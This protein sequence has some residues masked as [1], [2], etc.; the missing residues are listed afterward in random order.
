MQELA[1]D[2]GNDARTNG[3]AT[4][5]DSETQTDF[6]SDRGNQRNVHVD[7]IARAAHINAFRKI[8]YTSNVCCSEIELRTISGEERL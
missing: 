3:S 6:D 5:A 4:L 1:L 7:V 2:F 8:D